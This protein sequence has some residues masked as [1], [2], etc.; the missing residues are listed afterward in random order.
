MSYLKKVIFL[1]FDGVLHPSHFREGSE[2][3]RVP[4]L[5]VLVDDYSFEIVISSSWRF[6]HPLAQLKKKLG[7]QLGDCV[8]SATGQAS[9]SIHARFNEISEWLDFHPKC[10]WRAV[11][12]SKFEFPTDCRNLIL[13]DSKTGIAEQQINALRDWLKT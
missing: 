2:F 9:Q 1:D 4:L 11:D 5:E 3:S 8:I 6:H 13:C 10:D 7:K 12:D